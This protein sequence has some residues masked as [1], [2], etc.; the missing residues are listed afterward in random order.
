MSFVGSIDMGR[1]APLFRADGFSRRPRIIVYALAGLCALLIAW[2]SLAHVSMI[3]DAEGRVI[4]SGHAQIIQHLEGGVLAE[5]R[6]HEG[7]LVRKGQVLAKVSDTGAS[8]A[9]GGRM[10]R[11]TALRARI[12]RLKAEAGGTAMRPIEGIAASDPAYVSEHAA[13][14]ER[15]AQ[16]GQQIQIQRQQMA[17]RSAELSDLQG[18]RRS[19]STEAKIAADQSAILT[20]LQA[21]N[22]ASRLEVLAAQSRVQQIRTGVAETEGAIPKAAAAIAEARAHAAETETAFRAQARTDLAAAEAELLQLSQE[23]RAEQDRVVRSELRAPVSG[24]VNRL[25]IA[26][27]GGVLRPGDPVMEITPIDGPVVVEAR[28]SPRDRAELRP[29]LPSQVRLGAYDYAIFGAAPG[30]V[31]DV[32]ADTLPDEQGQRFYRVR[33][34]IDR[35]R[36]LFGNQPVLPGMTAEAGIVVGERSVLSFLFS[37]LMRFAQGAFRESR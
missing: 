19:L 2:A 28:V 4:P 15:T 36:G 13:F 11:M 26:T 22:S 29:G 18:R 10:A 8:A 37:P 7:D 3:V 16:L 27:N 30:R 31:I 24:V 17:Q 1:P 20:S 9:L 25:Y 14:L 32:S 23:S 34:A 12:S 5:L 6:V 35:R 33:I 21:R